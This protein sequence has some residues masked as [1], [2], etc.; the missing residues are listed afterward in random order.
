MGGGGEAD[1]GT[2]V[3]AEMEPRSETPLPDARAST[4]KP[5]STLRPQAPGHLTRVKIPTTSPP[6]GT[7][8]AP[9]P[10]GG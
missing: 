6:R 4:S 8:V 2:G 7:A 3:A 9:A 5:V 10:F 1:G